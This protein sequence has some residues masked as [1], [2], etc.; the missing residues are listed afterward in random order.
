MPN[1]IQI[2]QSLKY[3]ID[4]TGVPLCGMRI[5]KSKDKTYKYLFQGV[6]SGCENPDKVC[7][8]CEKIKKKNN[9]QV[10]EI[11]KK[12]VWTY[13]GTYG[14]YETICG[15]GFEFVDGNPDKNHFKFCPY[16]GNKIDE[17][18]EQPF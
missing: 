6:V 18:I 11:D 1:Y 17:N 8:R 9:P 5:R 15:H 2:R 10:A 7:K 3:H 16:C 12:C 4:F 13:N 14:Y